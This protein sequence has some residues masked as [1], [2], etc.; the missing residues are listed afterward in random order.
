M[1]SL[2]LR[3]ANLFVVG[4]AADAAASL[5]ALVLV[6]ADEASLV[7]G[8]Q[9][10]L[11]SLVYLGAI[12]CMPLLMICA[13]LPMP[14]L[15]TLCASVFWLASGA[16]P[17][18][19]AFDPDTELPAALALL[20]SG[21]AFAAL[22][23]IRQM[24]R[25]RG[26]LLSDETRP[27]PALSLA[28]SLRFVATLMFIIAPLFA[29]YLLIS[30]ATWLEVGTERFVRVDLS[31]IQLADRRY[32]R[33]EREIRLVG[34]M[35]LGE[36]AAYREL[37]ASFVA[38]NT[39]VLEE[40]VSDETR[41]LE[42]S[43]SYDRLA[44]SLGLH[45]QR[46]IADYLSAASG[47]DETRVWPVI[48]NADVDARAFSPETV[49]YLELVAGVWNSDTPGAAFLELYRDTLEHPDRAQLFLHDVIELRNRH[50]LAEIQR[51]LPMYDHVIVPW[52][53]LHLPEIE[54]DVLERGFVLED[55]TRRQVVGW[56][57][58]L[59]AIF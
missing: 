54:R 2:P 29:G 7:L 36:D 35:H 28:H 31:G 11:A 16:A 45:A 46:S 32:S 52:G 41:A 6:S 53:A 21:I 27:G 51:A 47:D 50:L 33:G 17:L 20:Q 38:E 43:L 49:A 5:I 4:Y 3:L 8:M 55:E 58:L 56:D 12:L 14:L 15:L 42:G 30:L 22:L 10:A 26:W 1:T 18:P 59:R 25:G 9:R 37:A 57:T 23:R 39:I 34:M 19:L 48:R 40:G 24:N 13:R 44:R